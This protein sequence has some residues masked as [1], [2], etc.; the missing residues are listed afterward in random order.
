MTRRRSSAFSILELVIAVTIFVLAFIPIAQ[1]LGTSRR[2]TASSMRLLEATTYAQTLL[3]GV[4]P[5]DESD[6]PPAQGNSEYPILSST[7]GTAAGQGRWSEVQSYF[8]TKPPPF[9]MKMRLVTARRL[10]D[11]LD[12][13]K[14]D[15]IV[16]RVTV[17][18]LRLV[19]DEDSEQDVVLEGLLDPRP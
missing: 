6:L 4:L 14:A 7:G 3:E 19:T 17:S 5:L 2:V 9:P 10:P 16:I 18:F 8:D 13:S 15:R 1:L 12:P 11:P